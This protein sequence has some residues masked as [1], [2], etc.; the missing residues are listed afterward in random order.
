MTEKPANPTISIPNWLNN[1]F[2]ELHLKKYFNDQKL[3]IVGFGIQSASAD[4]VDYY[5]CSMYRVNVVLNRQSENDMIHLSVILKLPVS[6][7]VALAAL[8]AN[9]VYKKEIEFYDQIVPKINE[10]LV[11]P[12]ETKQLFAE[13]YGVCLV[14]DVL[15][16]E[17]LAAKSYHTSSVYRGYNFDEAKLI[18]KKLASFHAINAV[19]QQNQPNIFENFKH[20]S[21]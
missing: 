1:D 7:D 2:F 18:L 17:D 16:L 15:L 4:D 13:C 14:N 9:N 19:L 8:V 10:A 6:N 11:Q 12:Y 21:Y 3:Q 20:G 5:S